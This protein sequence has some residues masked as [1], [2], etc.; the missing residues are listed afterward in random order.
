MIQ[1]ANFHTHTTFCDGRDTM[2]DMV[3]TAVEKGFVAL[4]FSGHSYGKYDEGYCMTRA[5]TQAYKRELAR[6]REK[7]A[8]QIRLYCGI[9][10]DDLAEDP[11]VGFDYVIAGVHYVLKDGVYVSVDAGKDNLVRCVNRYWNGDY[12][13]FAADYYAQLGGVAERHHP[14]FIAH[15]DLLTKFNEGKNGSILF[16]EQDPRYLAAAQGALD[17]LI[18]ADIPFEINTGAIARGYRK[19]PY[20]SRTMMLRIRDMGGRF[21]YSSD[22]HDRS[23]LDCGFDDVVRMAEEMNLR[24]V[25]FR[26]V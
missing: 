23:K 24:L 10:Q 1:K 4:G 3:R 15:F 8:G 21:I 7:Y 14:D 19:T 16:D 20:P 22:C 17:R 5:G 18:Q 13:A 12:Y 11:A 26:L 25:D 6:L 9:E 2:E